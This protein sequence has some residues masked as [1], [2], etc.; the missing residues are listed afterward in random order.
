MQ[1][2]R[3]WRE[4]GVPYTAEDNMRLGA[5][6]VHGSH[7]A[8]QAVEVMLAAVGTSPLRDGQ[9]MQRY[10]RDISVYK[11]HRVANLTD[12]APLLGRLHFGL[13]TPTP[14]QRVL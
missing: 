9:R 14:T 12:A 8:V 6:V 2:C 4:E 3:R 13:G 5:M 10:W 7:L 1:Y 11:A